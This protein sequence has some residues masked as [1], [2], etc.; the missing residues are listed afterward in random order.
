MPRVVIVGGGIAGLA[1]AR[2]LARG[3]G[4]GGSSV[5]VTLVEAADRLGGK[6][7]TEREDGF[8][9]EAGADSFGTRRPR[10]RPPR[11]QGG[12]PAEGT[13]DLV[14]DLG[15]AGD[16]LP[17][18]ADR[19]L[20]L[21][22][23][24]L[25]ALPRGLQLVVPTDLKEVF[26]SRLLSLP[27]KL[28]V[29]LEL[30]QRPGSRKMR[31]GDAETVA[32]FLRRHFGD[33][34]TD[35]IAAPLL[36]GIHSADPERLSLSAAFPMLAG[37]EAR[38]GSLIRGARRAA[39]GGPSRVTLAGGMGTLVDALAKDLEEAGVAIRTGRRVTA[40]EA[41]DGCF[42]LEMTGDAA[43]IADAVVL[44]TPPAVSASVLSGT[45]RTP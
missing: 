2:A 13:L 34:Y 17:T 19:V 15:L 38:H 1:A 21:R 41:G 18:P 27:G 20:V 11:G 39:T 6:I 35:R 23:G 31:E 44:A 10:P 9:V 24:R 40:I 33:E 16:L 4:E 22:R 43:L 14:E 26:R 5:R 32:S 30:S 37:L 45:R 25:E 12:E 42:R 7:F 3:S 36:A 29:A 28:R 8:L